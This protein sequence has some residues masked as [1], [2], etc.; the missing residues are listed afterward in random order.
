MEMVSQVP[1]KEGWKKSCRDDRLVERNDKSIFRT[2]ICF[3]I[4]HFLSLRLEIKEKLW[5]RNYLKES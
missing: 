3:I 5:M 1:T 2:F 4:K